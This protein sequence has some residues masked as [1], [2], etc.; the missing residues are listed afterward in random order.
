MSPE[1]FSCSGDQIEPTSLSYTVDVSVGSYP[2]YA[3]NSFALFPI[4]VFMVLFGL[5]GSALSLS[6]DI[7]LRKKV[8]SLARGNESLLFSIGAAETENKLASILVDLKNVVDEEESKLKQES[9][10]WKKTKLK[11]T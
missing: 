9:G 5:Y 6:Q 10:L 7:V 8:K 2:P 4:S 11:V 1:I 3:A